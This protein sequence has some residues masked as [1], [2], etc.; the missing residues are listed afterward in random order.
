MFVKD[1]IVYGGE[2]RENI[3]VSDIKIM[4]DMIMLLTF[5][6]G[7]VRLFDTTILYGEAFE[8]LKDAQIFKTARLDHG[9]VTWADGEIDC[10]PE[11]MYEH[12]YEYQKM[13]AEP[14]RYD[15]RIKKD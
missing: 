1:G 14:F 11:Y 13:V 6:N 7:E 4:P 5:S 15:T 8:P 9:V 10:S 12:S 3:K 2:P